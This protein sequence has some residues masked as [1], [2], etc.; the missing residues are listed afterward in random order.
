MV[1]FLSSETPKYMASD[2]LLLYKDSTWANEYDF[3]TR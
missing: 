2:E 1:P 3:V